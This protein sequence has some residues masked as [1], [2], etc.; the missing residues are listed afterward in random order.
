MAKLFQVGTL[1]AFLQGAYEGVLNI[2]D[3]GQKGNMG[4]GV[5]EALGGELIALDGVVYQISSNG[6]AS[7]AQEKARTPFAL[8]ADFHTDFSFKTNQLSSINALNQ[9][10]ADKLPTLN[11][12][13][14]FRI[15]A[16]L[17]W[18]KLRSENAQTPP[19]HPLTKT[20]PNIQHTFTLSPSKGTLVGTYAPDFSEA[21]TISGFHYHY[22]DDD[23]K[24]G[25][26]VFDAAFQQAHIDICMLRAF[27]IQL[28]NTQRFDQSAARIETH[29][30]VKKVEGNPNA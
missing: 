8:I 9:A 19:F 7:V 28:P 20:L 14:V 26:H 4:L 22:I 16:D 12:F 21:L 23:R 18:I 24:K 6:E 2:K 13:Y 17:Q 10:L 27:E 15:K 30:A 29:E 3:L 5:M 11:I 25:G 1:T